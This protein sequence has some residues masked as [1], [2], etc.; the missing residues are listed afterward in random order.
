MGCT[1]CKKGQ[2]PE[3]DQ[4]PRDAISQSNPMT[5]QNQ[6]AG[7]VRFINITENG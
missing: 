3:Q 5:N 4:P 2:V 1:V 7:M 6:S